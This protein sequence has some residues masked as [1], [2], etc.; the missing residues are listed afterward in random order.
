MEHAGQEAKGGD[1]KS[2]V[3]HKLCIKG[4][5]NDAIDREPAWDSDLCSNCYLEHV[6]S[7]LA[8]VSPQQVYLPGQNAL[9]STDE[10]CYRH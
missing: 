1:L 2:E 6:T 8:S 7:P 5:K 4:G 3:G 10:M 9:K